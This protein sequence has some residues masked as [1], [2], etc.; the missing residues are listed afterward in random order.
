MDQK[1]LSSLLQQLDRELRATDRIDPGNRELVQRLSE[2]IRPLL[3]GKNATSEHYRG[4]RERLAEA[5][6][7]FETEH[8]KVASAIENV[9]DT[10]VRMNL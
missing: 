10:L 2:D 3:A 1:E 9:I 8:P 6:T 4:L 7:G 5:V